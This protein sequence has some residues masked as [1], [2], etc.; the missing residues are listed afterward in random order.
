MKNPDI[1]GKKVE[2]SAFRDR[3][4]K[5]LNLKNGKREFQ[6]MEKRET[7][8]SSF[9]FIMATI[10]SA[11]GLGN[12]WKFPYITGMN[13]GGAFVIVYLACIL[14]LGVPV[15]ICEMTIGR[16]TR[17]NAYGAY[18]RLQLRRSIISDVIAGGLLLGGARR[19]NVRRLRLLR[20][21]F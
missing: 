8:G 12:V 9:G 6:N 18:K 15:M 17:L 7:W 16:K 10:G 14:L 2:I 11:I 5:S 13:G 1:S 20:S 21:S 19:K 3:L 4:G